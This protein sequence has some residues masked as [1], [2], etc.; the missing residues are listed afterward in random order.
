M[1]HFRD[2]AKI[3]IFVVM[4]LIPKPILN[5][6]NRIFLPVLI[7]RAWFKRRATDSDDHLNMYWDSG[8]SATRQQLVLLIQDIVASFD[9]EAIRM[10]EYGSHVG[11]NLKL[12]KEACPTTAFIMTA[13]EPNLEACI[14]LKT[15]LPDV[16]VIQGGESV[17]LRKSDDV[18]FK[19]HLSLVNSVFYSMSGSKTRRVIRR[20]CENSDYIVVGDSM[21]NSNGNK[22]KFNSE[23]VFFSH[24]YRKLFNDFGFEITE[25]ISAVDPQPQLDGFIVARRKSTN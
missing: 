11:V 21:I 6:L 9:E 12:I 4:K 22:L 14:F 5:R 19:F 15:K 17:F 13:L 8:N 24:P 2:R 1:S 3:K 10:F 7:R 23:P 25:T 16:E 18:R 20:L